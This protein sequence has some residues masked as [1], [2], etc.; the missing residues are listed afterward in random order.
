MSDP[1]TKQAEARIGARG[2]VALLRLIREWLG[3]TAPPP[4]AGMGDDTA[5]LPEGVGNLL[6]TDSLVYGRHFDAGL[7]PAAAGAKLLKRNLSDIAAMGGQPGVAV[8]AGFLPPQ[9]ALA[10]LEDFTRG[11]AACAREW[12]VAVVGGDLAET[13]DFLGFNLTLTGTAM[14]PLR[15]AAAEPGDEIWVTG[16]LGGSLAGHHAGFVP[17]LEEGAWLAGHVEVHSAIDV[18]DGLAKDLP[19]LLVPGCQAFL[20]LDRLPLRAAARA[21]ATASGRD[22]TAHA[23][24]DGEDY[25]LLFTASPRWRS[26][27]GE[28]AWARRFATPL[29]CIGEVR[30]GTGA[31]PLV[32]AATGQPLSFGSGYAHFG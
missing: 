3:D 13:T 23:L 4:P 8:L 25:E 12:G 20:Q 14:R 15:R 6:T 28:E 19:A 9:T 1:F 26:D 31:E 16:E 27:G 32:D 7:P 22:V 24:T 29:T 11:L 10:W 2:E 17:R 30:A 5:V 18:T 21:A